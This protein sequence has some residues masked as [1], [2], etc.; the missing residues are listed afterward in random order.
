LE[1]VG[2]NRNYLAHVSTA[3]AGTW[4]NEMN[5]QTQQFV[6]LE[7]TKKDGSIVPQ[8]PLTEEWLREIADEASLPVVLI[9]QYSAK[10][11]TI[12][13]LGE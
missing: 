8:R 13:I 12:K 2:D 9:R 3:E 11:G 5:F 6:M 4:N 7:W 10:L 1:K